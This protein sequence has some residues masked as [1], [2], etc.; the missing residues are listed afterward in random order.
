MRDRRRL[1]IP[2]QWVVVVQTTGD[3]GTV[4]AK[5]ATGASVT[6]VA[7]AATVVVAAR[8]VITIRERGN[9]IAGDRSGAIRRLPLNRVSAHK[10]SRRNSRSVRNL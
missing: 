10:N 3:A 1:A 6:T 4:A 8:V 5:G 9:P 7:A 2:S